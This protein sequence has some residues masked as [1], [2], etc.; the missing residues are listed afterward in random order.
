MD[1]LELLEAWRRGNPQ[2]GDRLFRRHIGAV[3][4]FFANKVSNAALV[5]DLIQ[6]TFLACIERP[7]GFAGRSSFRSYL[8]GIAK[9]VLFASFRAARKH[10][11]DDLGSRSVQDMGQGVSTLVGQSERQQLLLAA[12]R[13]IP[14]D[15]QVA[16]ELYFFED[17][18]ASEIAEVLEM[19]EGTVR[20]RIRLGKDALKKQLAEAIVPLALRDP[21]DGDLDTWLREI[22]QLLPTLGE[23]QA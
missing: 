16:L 13:R 9:F 17:L 23:V 20:S 21:S 5:E 1:D 22:R 14:L 15:Q 2:S 7:D 18:S 8:L 11:V 4:R 12:L 19:A 3:Q 10:D 6:K